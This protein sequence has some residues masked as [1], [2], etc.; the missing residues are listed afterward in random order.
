[1]TY[2]GEFEDDFLDL[3]DDE[4]GIRVEDRY[5]IETYDALNVVVKEQYT[6]KQAIKDDEGNIIQ[7]V[8]K[9]V[10]WR[11][12]SYHANL[13]QAFRSI[14]DKEINM[15]VSDGL[16]AVIDKIDELK[17]FKEGIIHGIS[18]KS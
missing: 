16:E 10:Q 15:T 7:T 6:P 14:V 12:I 9:E 17:S 8:E 2:V 4:T 18:R 13:E 5:K 1:M 3:C 11:A